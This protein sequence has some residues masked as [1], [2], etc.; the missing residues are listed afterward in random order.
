MGVDFP[1][2]ADF[3]ERDLKESP[4]LLIVFRHPFSG[5]E[6]GGRDLL[7][8]QIVDQG[9]IETCSVTHR[10][11]VKRQCDSGTRGRARFNHLGLREGE[12][13][14]DKQRGEDKAQ[15]PW[16][17]AQSHGDEYTRSRRLRKNVR[18][19]PE[20]DAP[21]VLGKEAIIHGMLKK[22][23]QQGRSE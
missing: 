21:C 9:L 8:D 13:R 12:P 10:A 15:Y 19:M 20:L 14:W 16:R 7:L 18:G 5:H 11:E 22:F 4:Y 23:V 1:M 3:K 6:E 2:G 17:V